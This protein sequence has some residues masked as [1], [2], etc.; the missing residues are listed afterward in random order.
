M[1]N[2]NRNYATDYVVHAH[3]NLGAQCTV[4][5]KR[6]GVWSSLGSGDSIHTNG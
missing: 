2:A 6:D 4:Q 1:S 5:R 3:Y